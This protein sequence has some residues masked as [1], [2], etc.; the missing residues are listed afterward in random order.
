M[1]YALV[2][3]QRR[4]A[5][6]DLSGECPVCGAAMVAKC[7]ERRVWHWAHRGRRTCDRWWEPETE[8]HRAWMNEFPVEWQEFLQRAEDGEKHIADVKTEHGRVIEFQHSYLRPEERRAREAFYSRMVWIVDGLRRKRDRS[9]FFNALRDARFVNSK[10]LTLSVFS[11]ECALLRDWADSGV[12]VF[13]DF[14]EINDLEEVFRFGAPVLWRLSPNS[15]D[16]RAL[17]TPVYRADFIEGLR[18]GMGY[19]GM[20]FKGWKPTPPPQRPLTRFD[21][22]MI[23]EHLT[24][25]WTRKHRPRARTRKCRPRPWTRM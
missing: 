23:R 10:R 13:F 24:R 4:E 15:P 12:P 18:T 6:P 3:R 22:Y 9:Q 5:R 7:G 1:K 16:G 14:G 11:D 2:D 8:W 20:A 25:E 19:R 21:L 17:L